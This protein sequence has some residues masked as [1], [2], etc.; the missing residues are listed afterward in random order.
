M[1]T[2]ATV[3][4]PPLLGSGRLGASRPR[5]SGRERDVIG[6]LARGLSYAECAASLGVALDT[7]RTHVRRSYEK[8][9]ASTK[10][11]AVAVAMRE[12]WID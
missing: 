8:L 3:G 5:L 6:L 7:V 2:I 4:S 1:K 10:A 9:H 11:E 12:G